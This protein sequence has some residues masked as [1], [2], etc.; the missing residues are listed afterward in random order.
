MSAAIH[1]SK[2]LLWWKRYLVI[3]EKKYVSCVLYL[4]M[5]KWKLRFSRNDCVFCI[6]SL[7]ILF[8]SGSLAFEKLESPFVLTSPGTAAPGLQDRDGERNPWRCRKSSSKSNSSISVELLLRVQ[9]HTRQ[10]RKQMFS[11][12]SNASPSVVR[13]ADVFHL[14][15]IVVKQFWWCASYNCRVNQYW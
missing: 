2:E 10:L 3:V 9:I 4:V 13:S 6:P 1:G 15:T 14:R 11:W 7:Y 12:D 5:F 8:L